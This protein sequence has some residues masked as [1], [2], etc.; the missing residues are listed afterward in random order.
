MFSGEKCLVTK[1]MGIDSKLWMF[2]EF[3]VTRVFPF[4]LG[5]FSAKRRSFVVKLARWECPFFNY[6]WFL[7]F[8][9]Y[10]IKTFCYSFV[11]AGFAFV[12]SGIAFR[13]YNVSTMIGGC[14]SNIKVVFL[15]EIAYQLQGDK[16]KLYVPCVSVCLY[17]VCFWRMRVILNFSVLRTPV[18]FFSR[19]YK[20]LKYGGCV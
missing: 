9:I 2:I 11:W 18:I 5:S 4:R 8:S 10:F 3:S 20:C 15:W 17:R 14:T 12:V 1:A 19:A 16:F 13:F 7:F 6:P